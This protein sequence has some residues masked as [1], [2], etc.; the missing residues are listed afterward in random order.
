MKCTYKNRTVVEKRVPDKWT[1]ATITS[2]SLVTTDLLL[3]VV[4]LAG[5]NKKSKT[6]PA[7]YELLPI[8]LWYCFSMDC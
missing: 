1:T 2:G 6:E 8:T 7:L 4:T 3:N 5:R